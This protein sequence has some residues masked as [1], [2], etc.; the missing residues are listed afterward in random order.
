[1]L[2]SRFIVILLQ[3]SWNLA[4]TALVVWNPPFHRAST[5]RLAQFQSPL[6]HAGIPPILSQLEYGDSIVGFRKTEH[7]LH[8]VTVERI[9]ATPPI[10]VLRKFCTA[11]E[12]EAIQSNITEMEPAQTASGLQE[13]I[14]RKKSFVAWLRNDEVDG[15][16]GR[17]ADSVRRMLLVPAPSLGV[18][19]MQVLR[20]DTGG[21]YVL[22][23]DGND[24]ILTV[25]YFL[26]GEGET[27][28][29]LAQT[30]DRSSD[31][32]FRPHARQEA[33]DLAEGQKPGVDGVM[34]STCSSE[35]TTACVPI[36]RGDAVAF[37]SYLNE[38]TLDWNA[39]HGG[40]PAQSE[41]VVANHFFRVASMSQ[42][43]FK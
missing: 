6:H 24:R 32:V 29:P 41:K 11:D 37:Y 27:W 30:T 4:T 43:R 9:A 33:L 31:N 5:R 42:D 35:R 25:L 22:H 38:G 14:I 36:G 23:H 10:F 17:L 39:I 19:D 13:N 28:F 16:V 1:M 20:Y 34:V 7:G 2:Q 21:E 40:L 3:F 26:N 8:N 18:E 15:V 12:C